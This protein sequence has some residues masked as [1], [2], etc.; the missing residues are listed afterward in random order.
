KHSKGV[1]ASLAEDLG[2]KKTLYRKLKVLEYFL[3]DPLH[4][5]LPQPLLGFRLQGSAYR[6]M[7][8]EA[9]GSLISE[10]L[11]LRLVPEGTNLALYDLKTG[12]KL[13]PIEDALNLLEETQKRAAE[14]EAELR[15]MRAAR[16]G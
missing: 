4:E 8:P 15:C 10:E 12:G 11:G 2:A 16:N 13:L 6:P 3:F 9:D 1:L 7:K 5:S 14:L